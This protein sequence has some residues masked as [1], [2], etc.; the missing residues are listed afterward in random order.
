M[1]AT[2]STVPIHLRLP[3]T[4]ANLGPGFDALGLALSLYLT[5]EASLTT[6]KAFSIRATGR[7]ADLCGNLENNLILGTYSDVLEQSGKPILPLQLILDNEIP[8]GMGCGSSAAALLAGVLLANHFGNLGWT[9]YQAMEEACRREGH[10]DNVAACWSGYMTASATLKLGVSSHYAAASCGESC[11]WHFMLALPSVSLAT[12]KAR[13]L[14][15][16]TYSRA[17]AVTNVQNAALLVAAFALDRGDLLRTAMVD[18]LHQPYRSASCPLL[19]LLLPMTEVS[20]VLGVALSGAGPSVLI[21][22]DAESKSDVKAAVSRRLLD[23]GHEGIELVEVTAS[24][25]CTV[26]LLR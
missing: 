17:D 2:D 7:N 6:D 22:S 23:Y 12:Q 20:G 4:S 16:D 21:V 9:G 26:R 1:S 3:A 18:R 11:K 15:P 25:G 8:L 24:K 5:I 13:A 14:L 19:P 10:P